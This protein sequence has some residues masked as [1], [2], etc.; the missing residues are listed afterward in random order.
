MDATF[1]PESGKVFCPP[2]RNG[3][4]CLQKENVYELHDIDPLPEKH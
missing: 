2:F 1:I 3:I 4:L